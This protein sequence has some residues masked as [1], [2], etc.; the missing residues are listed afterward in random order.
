MDLRLLLF[1][2]DRSGRP[3]LCFAFG[4]RSVILSKEPHDVHSRQPSVNSVNKAMSSS[5][6]KFAAYLPSSSPDDHNWTMSQECNTLAFI[7]H[8]IRML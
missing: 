1:T 4:D 8:Q 3:T 6:S 2:L 7:I 5:A